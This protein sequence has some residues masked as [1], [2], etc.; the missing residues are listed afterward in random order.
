M[1]TI[2][3]RKQQLGQKQKAPVAYLTLKT[4]ITKTLKVVKVGVPAVASKTIVP[5]WLSTRFT[6]STKQRF[7]FPAEV[8]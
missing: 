1:R 6:R 3:A 7:S 4:N 2:I 8:R 5:K